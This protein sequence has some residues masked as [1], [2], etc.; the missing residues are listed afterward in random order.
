MQRKYLLK[1]KSRDE[2]NWTLGINGRS[3]DPANTL[4][5]VWGC[6]AEVCGSHGYAS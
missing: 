3:K 4:R 1:E 6:H 2:K 5:E